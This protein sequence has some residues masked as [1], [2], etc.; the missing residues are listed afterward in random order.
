LLQDGVLDWASCCIQRSSQIPVDCDPNGQESQKLEKPEILPYHVL[1]GLSHERGYVG[2]LTPAEEQGLYRLKEMAVHDV[3]P[4]SPW[5]LH[6]ETEDR[7]LLRFLRARGFNVKKALALLNAD[8]QWRQTPSVRDLAHLKPQEVLGSICTVDMVHHYVPCRH[9]GYDRQ[10]R[11]I[12]YKNLG[13]NCVISELAKTC[14]IETMVHYHA[15]Q[16]E[17]YCKLLSEQSQRLGVCVEQMLFIVDADGWHLRLATPQALKFLSGI[18]AIDSHHYPERLGAIFVV[19]SPPALAI[20]WRI[21]RTYMPQRTQQKVHF[22]TTKSE[23]LA[24]L[25]P[26]AEQSQLPSEIL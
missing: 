7:F 13:R 12:V 1:S 19:N 9:V 21:V 20:A 15:W 2:N 6:G 10:G 5:L 8:I 11:P 14:P 4:L 18:A 22:L 25:L 17:S 16:Q 3:G 23:A 26:V 24:A